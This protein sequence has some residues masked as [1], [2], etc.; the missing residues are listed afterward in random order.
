MLTF[1]R[2]KYGN[3]TFYVT[4]NG[5]STAPEAG[6][7]DDGRVKYMRAALESALDAID[8]GVKLKGYMAW[9][10]MDNFEWMEGYT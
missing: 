10:L 3:I 6:S 2:D 7:N 9:S 5:W 1:L 8:A 4:E